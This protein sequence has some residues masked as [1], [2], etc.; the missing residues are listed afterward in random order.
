MIRLTDIKKLRN[1]K[2]IIT[3]DNNGIQVKHTL[4]EETIVK[5]SLLSPRE[6]SKEE[7][8]SVIIEGTIDELYNKALHFV[9]FQMR[10]ISEVKKHLKKTTDDEV[11]INKLIQKLKKQQ[12]LN[13]NNFVKEFVTQKIEFNLVGPKYIKDKL[14]KKGIH[15]DLIDAALVDFTDN[16][17]F[18]KIDELIRKELKYPIKKPFKKAYMSIKGKLVNKGFSLR[19]IESTLSSN[20]DLI[21][22]NCLEE[23]LLIKELSVLRKEYDVSDFKQKD[24]VIQKLL[25]K[26]YSYINIKKQL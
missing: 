13:D 25:Q 2:Y 7:Y 16:L 24:K 3:I 18:G 10:T 26:G 22:E 9:D 17:Q 11:L 23:E 8:N 20:S 6:I 12:Y 5:N 4:V 1:S 21:K 15:F 14:I 19:V